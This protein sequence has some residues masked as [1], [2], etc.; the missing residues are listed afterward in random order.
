M[1]RTEIYN[2]LNEI[3]RR[4]LEEPH[5]FLNENTTAA[6]V[7]EWDSITNIQ[8]IVSIER[9]FQVSFSSKEIH[10]LKKV[11]DLVDRIIEKSG[12]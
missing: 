5:I 2:Q 3:F 7:D 9:H 1:N 4:E 10:E 6:D 11:G 12:Y 8:L